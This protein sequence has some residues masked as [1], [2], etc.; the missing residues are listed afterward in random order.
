MSRFEE[1]RKMESMKEVIE[2][3]KESVVEFDDTSF[4]K[5]VEKNCPTLASAVNGSLG[6]VNGDKPSTK[7]NLATIYGV[8]FK[9][10]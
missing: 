2:L 3:S 6:I 8:I 1:V 5:L 10:R 4:A 9:T 7:P